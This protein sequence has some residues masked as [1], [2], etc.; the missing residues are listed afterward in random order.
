MYSNSCRS[1]P[2]R[3]NA[4]KTHTSYWR[5]NTSGVDPGS[6]HDTFTLSGRERKN[7]TFWIKSIWWPY[8]ISWKQFEDDVACGFRVRF[9]SVLLNLYPSAAAEIVL[10]KV[11]PNN[12]WAPLSKAGMPRGTHRLQCISQYRQRTHSWLVRKLFI[13]AVHENFHNTNFWQNLIKFSY[14]Q[15]LKII[16]SQKWM[17]FL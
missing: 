15:P 11:W 10:G 14:R 1:N 16:T 9:S 6:L 13:M 8:Y 5:Q 4:H 7:E 17:L 12:R 2:S 3:R